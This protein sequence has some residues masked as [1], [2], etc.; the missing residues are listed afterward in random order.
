MTEYNAHVPVEAK[1][2]VEM[3]I[4]E[5]QR[6]NEMTMLQ[7]GVPVEIIKAARPA[8]GESQIAHA[9]RFLKPIIKGVIDGAKLKLTRNDNGKIADFTVEY[10]D[11]SQAGRQLVNR[12]SQG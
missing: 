11:K 9:A 2:A 1:I 5:R 8:K 4:T 3:L 12:R 10:A 7:N 6:Q